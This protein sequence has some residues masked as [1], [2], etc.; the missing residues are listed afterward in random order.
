[1]LPD[2]RLLLFPAIAFVAVALLSVIVPQSAAT[3]RSHD[4]RA[5]GLYCRDRAMGRP[6]AHAMQSAIWVWTTRRQVL[7]ISL[8]ESA[9]AARL[10]AQ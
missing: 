9:P 10:A 8:T 3:P 6:C 5:A 2:A 4:G 1:M 7:S